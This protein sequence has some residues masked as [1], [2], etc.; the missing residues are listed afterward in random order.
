MKVLI[1]YY[2][3][4]G[5]VYKMAKLV[6]EG[7]NEVEGAEAVIR[8]VPEL[9]PDSLV[10]SRTDMKAGSEMQKDIAFVT[11]NDFKE[12]GA[13]AFGS[14]TRFGNVA[15]Q[16]KNQIDQLGSL[17]MQKTFEGKP[18]GAFVSTGSLHGGQESTI[19]SLMNVILHLGFIIVGVPYSVPDLFLTKGGGAPY[20]PGHV[21][22]PDNTRE[23]DE[24]EAN[25]CRYFGKRLAEIGLRQIK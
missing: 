18:A 21:A 8:K 19:L 17:W 25:I 16:L 4:F 23:I 20:G 24:N 5:N 11:L 15:A 14:P 1:V 13:V 2:S 22:G 9:M 10:Q 12:A 7:V 3:S 6:A